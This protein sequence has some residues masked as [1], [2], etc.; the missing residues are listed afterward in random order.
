MNHVE[1]I[2]WDDCQIAPEPLTNS[3]G[4]RKGKAWTAVEEQQLVHALEQ[5]GESFEEIA[6][7]LSR[8]VGAVRSRQRHLARQLVQVAGMSSAD[9]CRRLQLSPEELK[10]ALANGKTP[11]RAPSKP[12]DP[13]QAQILEDLRGLRVMIQ[14]ISER[15]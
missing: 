13:F 5:G 6:K 2:A 8:T 12:T 10:Y 7:K 9:V 15:V 14:S 1:N 11:T 4:V 3:S